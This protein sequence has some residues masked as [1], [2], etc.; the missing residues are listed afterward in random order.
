MTGQRQDIE[1]MGLAPAGSAGSSTEK[2]TS[3]ATGTPSREEAAAT[4]PPEAAG[5]SFDD[6]PRASSDEPSRSRAAEGREQASGDEGR[7]GKAIGS[8]VCAILGMLFAGVV[9]G[10][11]AVV[12]GVLARRDIAARPRLRGSGMAMAGIVIGAIAFVLAAVL[13][14]VGGHVL[15]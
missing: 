12:L 4:A 2:S 8:L 11:V 1:D 5:R 10:L 6:A 13:L 14:A 9:L 7:S 3:S 15:G